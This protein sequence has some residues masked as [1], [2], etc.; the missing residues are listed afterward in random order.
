MYVRVTDGEN[1]VRKLEIRREERK[2]VCTHIERL[3]LVWKF[4]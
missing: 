3:T 2:Q 4:M 1:V